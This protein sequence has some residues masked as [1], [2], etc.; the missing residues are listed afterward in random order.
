MLSFCS[1]IY[2][3]SINIVNP[4]NR[5]QSEVNNVY[6]THLNK[7]N[8]RNPTILLGKIVFIVNSYF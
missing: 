8:D 3:S 1:I 6:H 5:A 7:I 4:A 2:F